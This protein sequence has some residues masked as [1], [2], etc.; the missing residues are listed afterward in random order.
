MRTDPAKRTDGAERAAGAERTDGA[1]DQSATSVGDGV[2]HATG[3]GPLF[4]TSA[5]V[6]WGFIAW[7]VRGALAHHLDTRPGE[8]TQFFVEGALIHDLLF[9]PLVLAAG[10]GLSRVVPGKVR[11]YV[12]A[13]LIISGCLI[14][15]AYPEIRDYAGAQHNPT[16]LPYNYTENTLIAIAAVCT[17]TAFVAGVRSL[18]NRK[19]PEATPSS[20]CAPRPPPLSLARESPR[21]HGG[22]G[23]CPT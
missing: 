17:V 18:L 6:G 14:L 9:A 21:V 10:F 12:Q 20:C 1:E 13:V 15:F 4:W 5:L 8:L 22:R 23:G 11:A 2:S 16:S 19:K 7:G 3:R